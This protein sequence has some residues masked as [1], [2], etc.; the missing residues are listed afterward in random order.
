MGAMIFA[1]LLDR[2][3]RVKERVRINNFPANIGRAYNNDLIIDD[4]HVCP[5]HARIIMNED[6]SFTIEDAQSVNGFCDIKSN[7]KIERINLEQDGE[8]RIRLGQTVIR[9]R[10]SEYKV[11]PT[12]FTELNQSIKGFFNMLRTHPALS[13]SIIITAALLFIFESYFGEYHEKILAPL[14]G[15]FMLLTILICL[16]AGF[17]SVINRLISHA[18]RFLSHVA[19][20]CA[21]IILISFYG[22]ANEF[23]NFIFAF[24]LVSKVIG[25]GGAV[26]ILGWI[27]YGHLSIISSGRM[28]KRVIASALISTVLVGA[29]GAIY[30]AEQ[31]EF[32]SSIRSST[33]LKPIRNSMLSTKSTD[34]FFNGLN[35]LRLKVDREAKEE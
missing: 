28:L 35:S 3:N 6:G 9:F 13:V 24:D 2:R 26:V 34:D 18:F 21:G 27:L 4:P 17:W 32:S 25:F 8:V 14:L 16:W 12:E 23:L 1:E 7:Q 22:E 30:Y 11:M 20:A 19:V 29:V 10:G 31:T 33:E 15:G 5:Q